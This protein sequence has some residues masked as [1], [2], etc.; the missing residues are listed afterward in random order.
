MNML[1]KGF[2]RKKFNY[3]N[4]LFLGARLY[5]IIF[6]FTSTTNFGGW[7]LLLD[8]FLKKKKKKKEEEGN[9]QKAD[10]S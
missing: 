7:L 1:F 2:M 5:Y 6:L 4:G 8:F 3:K 9:P 10:Y